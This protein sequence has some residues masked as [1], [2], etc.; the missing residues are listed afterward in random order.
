MKKYK[1]L[2]RILYASAVCVAFLHLIFLTISNTMAVGIESF[3]LN[4][5]PYGVPIF[6]FAS[7]LNACREDK[8]RW[9]KAGFILMTLF[10]LSFL[11][12]S[13]HVTI[14]YFVSKQSFINTYF[15]VPLL[16]AVPLLLFAMLWLATKKAPEQKKVKKTI[17]DKIF[18]RLPVALLIAMLIHCGV[19]AIIDA[20]RLMNNALAT[21]A[22]WWVMPLVIALAYIAA[23]GVALLIRGIYNYAQRHRK[24]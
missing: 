7:A 11:V 12:M 22:P 3:F 5:I 24:E 21:S 16:Y 20:V 2:F 15:N 13:A 17:W 1:T 6:A 4:V 14:A 9:S 10:V 19:V 18:N 23:I 8:P